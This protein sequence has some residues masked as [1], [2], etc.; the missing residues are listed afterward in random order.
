[1]YLD[2]TILQS[3]TTQT[4]VEYID[5][6]WKYLNEEEHFDFDTYS[7]MQDRYINIKQQAEKAKNKRSFI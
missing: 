2:E 5:E 3:R 4:L 6:L 1:M 7:C